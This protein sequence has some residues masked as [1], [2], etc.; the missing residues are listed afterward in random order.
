MSYQQQLS[1]WVIHQQLPNFKRIVVARFRHRNDSEAYLRLISRMM[2]Q[3]KF[4]I[5]FEMQA[6]DAT[7]RTSAE[8]AQKVPSSVGR[9]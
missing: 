1:P 5:A 3:A 2:P 7:T 6:S 9:D 8:A 4:A